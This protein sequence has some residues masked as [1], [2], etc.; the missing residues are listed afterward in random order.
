MIKDTVKKLAPLIITI[1]TCLFAITTILGGENTLLVKYNLVNDIYL[2]R[3]DIRSY[4][5]NL[6]I[7]FLDADKIFTNLS[8]PWYNTVGEIYD[9]V[10]VLANIGNIIIFVFKLWVM[11]WQLTM[12]LV[13]FILSLIGLSRNGTYAGFFELLTIIQT[14]NIPYIQI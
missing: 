9:V 12:W 1:F 6:N 10:R 2:Y 13:T 7:T 5:D 3:V 14:F 8:M 4:I 11:L